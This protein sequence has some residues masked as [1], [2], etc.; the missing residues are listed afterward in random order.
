VSNLERAAELRSQD[1]VINDHLGDAYWRVGRLME[2]RFQ[3]RRA[4][5]LKP[6]AALSRS[7]EAKLTRG[8]SNEQ[9]PRGNAQETTAAPNASAG[10]GI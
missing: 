4:L 2:A 8:L 9:T 7:I 6:E 1:P 5:S 3:W 10:Q